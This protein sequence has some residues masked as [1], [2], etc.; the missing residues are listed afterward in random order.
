MDIRVK[1]I[2]KDNSIWLPS[3]D[4]D[5]KKKLSILMPTFGRGKNGF[6]KRAVTS[7]IEQTFKDT[8]L[9][10]IDDA[11]TDGT[12]EQIDEFMKQ[13]RRISCI[14]HKQ[15]MGLPAISTYE[16]LKKARGEYIGFLF[17][18]CVLYPSAYERTLKKMEEEGAQASYGRVLVCM[19]KE[20]MTKNEM[21]YYKEEYLDNLEISNSI[22]NISIIFKKDILE[23]I[24]YLDPH[25][26]LSRVNDW[27]FITR[28][29]RK[30]Y[31][32][33]TGVVFAKE[34][35]VTQKNSLGNAYL[36]NFLVV[37]EYLKITN[38]EKRLLL[39]NYEEINIFSEEENSSYNFSYEMKKSLDFFK[40]KYWL[41]TFKNIKEK[42]NLFDDNV[43]ILCTGSIT[44]SIS[45]IFNR[46]C[47]DSGQSMFSYI[48]T[49]RNIA[50]S[51]AVI[52][53]RET[54]M[55]S[56]LLKKLEYAG[57][58]I[59]FLWD[60]DFLL[61]TKEKILNLNITETDFKKVAKQ[62]NGLIFTSKK[63]Y[64]TY[65]EKGY[66]P[67][68]YLVN[69]VY[70]DS[71]EK[72]I[73]LIQDNKLNIAFTGGLWRIKKFMNILVDILNNIGKE[74][75]VTLY[76]LKDKELANVF[77]EKRINF[78]VKWYDITLS[79]DQLINK[80][81]NKNIH[82]LIHPAQE[83]SNNV[84]KTKNALVTAS[85]LGAALI[86]TDGAPYNMKDS[87]DDP[88]PYLLAINEE[89]YWVDAIK[90][91]LDNNVRT[92]MIKKARDYCKKRYSARCLDELI[93]DVLRD[94]PKVDIN[95]YSER[96]EKLA[97]F[98]GKIISNGYFNQVMIDGFGEDIIAT[99]KIDKELKTFFFA[100]KNNFST[101]SI[102]FGTHQRSSQGNCK[103]KVFDEN[104]VKIHDEIALLDEIVDN[105]FYNIGLEHVENAIGKKFYI[106][107]EFSY[108]NE[109]KISVYERNYKYSN[110]RIIRNLIRPFRKSEIYVSLS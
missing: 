85:L 26:C 59:Y 110:N 108:I 77:H 43:A 98:T 63:F 95:L 24:G 67:N 29:K 91:L 52:L 97:F 49:D 102:I 53:V 94:T 80:L 64:Q 89:K 92:E 15:N 28:I 87:D 30:F 44:S 84:N 104:N 38:R 74:K 66:N 58:P 17:D 60:D 5:E 13:D 3:Q 40:N 22:G 36:I 75:K 34:Y 62:L 20:D 54:N 72:E 7:Y 61:L 27:D 35:G 10:I 73:S 2:I 103:I 9:I 79:Y 42:T 8:E 76:L 65:E 31:L 69:P 81:N 39:N 50:K 18:D 37:D 55:N 46:N 83:T 99:K 71:L 105:K 70:L 78:T 33:E 21:F 100:D 82:I 96:L 1:D 47:S 88:M 57:I 19:D 6:F 56:Y 16:A 23:T 109:N 41:A 68:N 32:I 107:F 14:R 4:Y 25:V 51:R 106:S 48:N 45:L 86:T 93:E 90:K 11:N 101:I 12:S